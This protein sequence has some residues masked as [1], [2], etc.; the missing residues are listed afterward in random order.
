RL[1]SLKRKIRGKLRLSSAHCWS[2]DEW[3]HD[4]LLPQVMSLQAAENFQT[5]LIEYV[6]LS[7][8]ASVF[9]K[10]V[11]TVIDI[12]DL[13]GNR[14]ERYIK[15]QMRPTW[16]ATTI[17]EEIHALR[18]ADAV[19]AIQSEEARYLRD[20]RVHEV[21]SVGHISSDRVTPL[22]DP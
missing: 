6:F 22:S 13:F 12:H 19:I 21:F 18:R 17:K 16:F 9:P 4:G 14:H 5:V 20:H 8:L 2:V 11:R 7:K 3:F 15:N 10:S 1:A